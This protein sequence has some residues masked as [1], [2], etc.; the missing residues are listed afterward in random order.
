MNRVSKDD[1]SGGSVS[2]AEY[3]II[4]SGNCDFYHKYNQGGMVF[5]LV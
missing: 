1:A 3:R 2:S 5:L 4:L